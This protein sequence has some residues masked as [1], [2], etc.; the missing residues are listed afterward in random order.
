MV[1]CRILDQQYQKLLGADGKCFL[2]EKLV[3]MLMFAFSPE[4]SL[5]FSHES[6]PHAS[7][8]YHL[9]RIVWF[10]SV[11]SFQFIFPLVVA[12]CHSLELKPRRYISRTHAVASIYSIQHGVSHSQTQVLY[13]PEYVLPTAL[14]VRCV[15]MAILHSCEQSSS[16]NSKSMAWPS[17]SN[18]RTYIPEPFCPT[19]ADGSFHMP[20]CISPG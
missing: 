3:R 10:H 17:S 1:I 5:E 6:V 16:I 2:E 8:R 9:I 11:C 13:C 15:S 18:S 19:P 12:W 4:S 14:V 20:N 7:G